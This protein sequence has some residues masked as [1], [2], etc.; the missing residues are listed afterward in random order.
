[1]DGVVNRNR[2]SCHHNTRQNNSCK[3]DWKTTNIPFGARLCIET[4]ILFI[5]IYLNVSEKTTKIFSP[6]ARYFL[7]AL[8]CYDIFLFPF[9]YLLERMEYPE[10]RK[11][12]DAR[13]ARK[14][15]TRPWLELNVFYNIFLLRVS[16]NFVKSHQNP[17]LW[18]LLSP[19]SIFIAFVI[20]KS[21]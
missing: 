5:T 6:A 8:I 10:M 16:S 12:S 13:H 20:Q 11:T 7:P 4:G 2:D 15:L 21:R 3:N 18:I 1:V 19:R 14:Y 9:P 17:A